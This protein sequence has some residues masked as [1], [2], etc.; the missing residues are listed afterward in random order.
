MMQR[1]LQHTAA[2]ITPIAITTNIHGDTE[3]FS[4][5]PGI[6]E[7]N[8]IINVHLHFTNQEILW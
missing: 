3:L 4:L 5:P 2:S 6:L 8:I 7:L 1:T